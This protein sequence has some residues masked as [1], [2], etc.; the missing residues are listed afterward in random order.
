MNINLKLQ[1]PLKSSSD[2]LV[3]KVIKTSSQLFLA[4]LYA[5][6]S[7]VVTSFNEL[8]DKHLPSLR[9]FL[10]NNSLT[11]FRLTKFLDSKNVM[12]K[13]DIFLLRRDLVICMTTHDLSKTVSK[14]LAS[15]LSRSKRLGDFSVSTSTKGDSGVILRLM[16][17]SKGCIDEIKDLIKDL[18]L[19]SM[20]PATFVKGRYNPKTKE[21]NR[22]WWHSDLPGNLVDGFASKK[23]WENGSRYKAGGFNVK[24]YTTNYSSLSSYFKD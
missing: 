15:Q 2:P 24:G 3:K 9:M 5:L 6:E 13:E 14:D 7:D 4:P 16:T 23:Y 8:H 1:L 18:E 19:S 10:F 20:L 21:S 11:V 22:L 17:D 12:S